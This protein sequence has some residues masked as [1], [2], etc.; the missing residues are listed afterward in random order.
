MEK[1]AEQMRSP[2]TMQPRK[3][4]PLPNLLNAPEEQ[5]N[6]KTTQA[7]DAAVR[8]EFWSTLPAAKGY[9][10][11]KRREQP[12]PRITFAT[13]GEVFAGLFSTVLLLDV[14]GGSSP[15][16]TKQEQDKVH[17]CAPASQAVWTC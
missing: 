12:A 3:P 14:L 4:A 9:L 2:Q 1:L 10:T 5:H 7:Q 13:A 17:R 11:Q 15:M 16:H 6:A 8:E